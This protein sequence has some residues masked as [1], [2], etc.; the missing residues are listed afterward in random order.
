M[1]EKRSVKKIKGRN[2]LFKFL[3]EVRVCSRREGI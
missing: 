2:A 3:Q 1:K